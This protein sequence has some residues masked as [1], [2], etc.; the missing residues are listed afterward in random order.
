MR[1]NTF[2]Q[3]LSHQVLSNQT[4]DLRSLHIVLPNKRAKVFLLNELRKQSN[5]TI[6][7]P[8]IISIEELIQSISNIRSIDAIEMLFE[9]YDV[10]LSITSKEEQ[11]P[12]DVFSNW[13]KTAIQDFNEIDRYLIDPNY[14]FSYLSDV[15]ALERWQ[16]EHKDVTKLIDTHLEFWKKLPVYYH[17][18][19]ATL[20]EKKIGY[21]GLI[22]REAVFNLDVFSKT[23]QN[24]KFIFAGFNALNDAEEKIILHLVNQ[25]DAEVYWDIDDYFLNNSYHDVGLFI[26]R[27][28]K[29]WKP[30]YTKP[31]EWI[32]ND[33]QQEKNIEI[34]GTP[35]SIGQ[36]K[37]AGNIVEKLIHNGESIDNTAIVLG[38]ENLLLPVLNALPSSVSSLNIT[39]GYPS[40][41]N[42][43]QLLISYIFKL[44]VNAIARN[45][46]QYVFYYK[47]V[48]SVLN[49]PLVEPYSNLQEIV[50][51]IRNENFTFFSHDTLVKLKDQICL[52]NNEFFNLL[53]LP[54]KESTE[55]ILNRLKTILSFIK[56]NLNHK[57]EEEKI[58][59]TFIHSVFKSL[60]KILTYQEKFR[61]INT[62]EELQ[63]TYK[64]L[65]DLAEVSFE[66]QPLT[67]L[68]VM[69]VLES[70]VLDFKNV[71][72]TSVNEGKFPSGKSSNSFIP[73]DIKKELGLPTFKEKDAIYSYHFYHLLFRAKNI[74]LLYN[75]DN[76]G[77]DAGEKSRFLQQL[78]IE[79][80]PQHT[81]KNTIYN[82]VLPEKAYQKIE[83]EK[84]EL[85]LERL[86]EIATVKGFSPSSL[87]TYM[88]NPIQF[89]FQ[90]VLRI[91]DAEEVEENIAVNTLGT[92]IHEVLE[93]L[94]KPYLENLLTVENI[95]EML[96]KI[97]DE[98]LVQFKK[99]YK[100]GNIKKGKNY[101]A[102]E[103]A[104]RNVFN[105]L[106]TEKQAIENGEQIKILY[107]E[108]PLSC[109]IDSSELP[110]PIKI[111]GTVDRIEER[112][113][114]IRIT[115]YK[116][117]KV[118]A[119]N[120]KFSTF[121][122]L[123][124]DIKNEKIIQLLCY[125]LMYKQE[126][127]LPIHG[128]ETGIISFKNLK[129]GF[130]PLF[131]EGNKFIDSK[132][133][134]NFT[135]EIIELVAEILNREKV[136][137]EI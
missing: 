73:F 88:R 116:T 43:A 23:N 124:L 70:R 67:G 79:K 115:D 39:M 85:L 56:S 19:Y 46:N 129:N 108:K 111:S 91:N 117:G 137:K 10:Y 22:Y 133:L 95:D 26:R 20:K 31:F 4:I 64:Q 28:K 109:D 89:Y 132:I 83:I 38:D 15:K 29:N 126:F 12:F 110:F 72:I 119:N 130:L 3:K 50:Q 118:E 52:E 82:A 65:I 49:H 81:I 125:A 76:E 36:A 99:V 93:A 98:V 6:F 51:K 59:I 100:E 61:K 78:E 86:K 135:S 101:L 123:T 107:L 71:I 53:F 105:F 2:I 41:N 1:F 87:T 77:I 136:F 25:N 112:N 120:L 134:L 113:G 17:K 11:Q 37:I 54:W 80:L 74:F 63:A 35:K 75:T 7:A 103:V 69:G 13:A 122:G 127:G 44:H 48:I 97:E 42:P 18:L 24:S 47:D 62:I 96:V 121:E 34:I 84:S 21:Q 8:N 55:E 58:S 27:F 66:G 40:K 68:Q 9:F 90:R 102:F 94:Y 16:L 5:Q 32:S 33:F 106:K 30:Y 45:K 114:I 60:N 104:K 131:V 92:I 14:V 128:I 57:S